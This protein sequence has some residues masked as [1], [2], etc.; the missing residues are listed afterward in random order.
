[1]NSLC[2]DARMLRCGGI[3]TY[4]QQ[5]IPRIE[6]FSLTLIVHS[7]DVLQ[8]S[9]Y[10]T[11]VCDAPIYSIREQWDLWREIGSYDLFWSPHFNIPL[12]PI[13][14]KRRVVTIH[15]LYHLAHTRELGL[16]ERAYA[17]WVI[18]KA[19]KDADRVITD[20]EFSRGEIKRYL[21]VEEKIRVIPLGVEIVE[22][23]DID[24]PEKFVLFVGNNKKHKNLVSLVRAMKDRKEKLIVVGKEA[25]GRRAENI[26]GD[27]IW[28]RDVSTGVLAT[29]YSRAQ[30]T[31]IPSYY[32]GFGLVGL[33]AMAY[34]C[35]VVASNRAS[36]PEVYG[37]A[38]IYIDPDD[39]VSTQNGMT[40]AIENREALVVKGFSRAKLFNWDMTAKRHCEVFQEI[41]NLPISTTGS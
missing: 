33:E 16:V 11:I 19:I 26:E 39:V 18:R 34:G 30:V 32:E 2:I 28:M 10:K 9:Q 29:L 13:R 25:G 15:D 41:C 20:S 37:D 36:L 4:L 12:L 7:K 24:L 5:I 35:P 17:K 22:L 1:M 27:V 21:A 38:A 40:R 6:G 31:V 23:E 8:W 14:A 3:G